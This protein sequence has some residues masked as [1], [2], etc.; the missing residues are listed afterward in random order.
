MKIKLSLIAFILICA[1]LAGPLSLSA[2]EAQKVVQLPPPQTDAGK[3]LMQV[4][5]NRHSTRDFAPQKLSLQT[6]SNL[7]WAADGINRPDSGKRTAPTAMNWQEIDI[8]VTLAEGVYLY[9]HKAHALKLVLAEDLRGKTGLQ[10][11]VKDAPL[12]LVYVADLSRMPNVED[13]DRT[14]YSAVDTGFIAENVYL[15]CASEGLNVVV[16]GLVDRPTLA[17]AL[18]L[19]PYQKIVLAQTVGYPK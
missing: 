11:F 12:N 5:K 3:P 16:R 7:L 2:E 18:K 13:A 9:D 19:K 1:G 15:Y 17:G 14:L 6:L 8:Y 10:P 4:L